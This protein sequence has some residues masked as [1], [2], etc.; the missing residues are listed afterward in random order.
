MGTALEELA[1]DI[2]AEEGL[3][4]KI[5]TENQDEKHAGGIYL[6]RDSASA[7]PG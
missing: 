6:F 5:W 7:D 4:W 1:G 2:A 3:I